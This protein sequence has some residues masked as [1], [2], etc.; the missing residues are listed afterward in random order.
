MVVREVFFN[1]TFVQR[2][3]GRE[4][5]SLVRSG[6]E[7]LGSAKALEQACGRCRVCLAVWLEPSGEGDEARAE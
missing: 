6:E 7:R 3:E 4:G 2:L 1:V 5:E